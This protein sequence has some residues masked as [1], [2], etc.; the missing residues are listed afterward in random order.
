M[1]IRL[2]WSIKFNEDV[3]SDMIYLCDNILECLFLDYAEIVPFFITV[4]RDLQ[5]TKEKLDQKERRV[6]R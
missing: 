4:Y 2:K 6:S 5:G 1:I 3:L